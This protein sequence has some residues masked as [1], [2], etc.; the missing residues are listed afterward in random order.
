M[1]WL[2]A[3]SLRALHGSPAGDS[4]QQHGI[5]GGKGYNAVMSSTVPLATHLPF[6]LHAVK[7]GRRGEKSV[8]HFIMDECSS[9]QEGERES[10]EKVL[11][12]K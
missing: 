11:I 5:P 9:F 7:N 1:E 8:S 6:P 12:L 4:W 3:S 10:N 2:S